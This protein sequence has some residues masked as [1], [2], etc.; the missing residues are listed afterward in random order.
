ML[1]T[2]V[3]VIILT[4][5]TLVN[6]DVVKAQASD[7]NWWKHAVFYQIYPRSFKDS[8]NDGIGDL[9][10]IIETLD[11]FPNLGVNAVWL[12]P[13]FKSPQV[14]Q[15]Y[16]ISDYRDV[17][18]DYGT[19]ED[20]QELIQEAHA[21]GIRVILDFVP[22]HTS[23]KHQ[24]FI[25]SIKGIEEYR[26]YYIWANAKTDDNGNRVPP[27]NWISSFKNSAWTWNE[28][29]QQYY[30]HQFASAQPDL[31]YRNPK[32]VEAMKDVLRF[33]L[34][35]GID[36]FRIDA[37]THLFEDKDLPDEPKSGLPGYNDTDYEYLNHI[38][39]I[40]LPETFDMVYQWRQ[41]VDDYTKQDGGDQRV[42]MTEA[43]SDVNHT[44][45]YYGTADGRRLGAHFTF[46]FNFIKNIDIDSTAY[47]IVD[48][49]INK[50]LNAIP[51]IYT[52]DFE[53]TPYQWDTSINAGFNTGAKPWLPVSEKYLKTN[54][55]QEEETDGSSHYKIYQALVEIRGSP[56]IVSGDVEVEAINENVI[57][58]KRSYDQS[59]IAVFFNKGN[60][61]V[62]VSVN[63]YVPNDNNIEIKSINSL[64]DMGSSIDPANL[65]LDAHEALVISF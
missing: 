54:L 47:D 8:N 37:I 55:Q 34:D 22:N 32:V 40:N 6:D 43:Y 61:D 29:R 36:G 65:N 57:L 16:D 30:L 5:S 33:W 7:L 44:M 53:R 48:N 4:I 52:R 10:G 26:D 56:T 46:N 12:S 21:K 51:A 42:L 64:R 20:L 58:M 38:Y 13:I 17:D 50:W 25:D 18:P 49:A 11:H 9:R 28:E 60:E 35:Q 19:I 39:T 41:L 27:N 59:S 15:G 62:V 24:W 14:D 1:S 31:N 3:T 45:L 2:T 23:D 63:D